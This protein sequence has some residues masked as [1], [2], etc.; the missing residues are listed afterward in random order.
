MFNSFPQPKPDSGGNNIKSMQS[1]TATLGSGV[2]TLTVP[3]SEVN[4]SRAVV[5]LTMNANTGTTPAEI[6]VRAMISDSTTVQLDRSSGG[7]SVTVN[8]QVIEFNNV[9]SLQK[10][11]FGV[12]STQGIANISPV[13]FAKTMYFWSYWNNSTTVTAGSYHLGFDTSKVTS[14]NQIIFKPI[15]TSGTKSVHWQVVEF[16]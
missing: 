6:M 10:G 1:G 9:K 2:A 15:D 12:G 3:I 7:N 5:I 14:N 16:N 11:T 4:L 13:V 8:W